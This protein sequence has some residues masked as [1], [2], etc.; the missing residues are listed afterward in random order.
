MNCSSCNNSLSSCSCVDNCPNRTSEFIFDGGFDSIIVPD[1]ANLNDVLLLLEQYTID[2]V[3]NINLNY[4]LSAENCIGLPA[5]TYGY[6]QIFDAINIAICS[7]SISVSA[8]EASVGVIDLQIIDIQTDIIDIQ[9][10]ITDINVEI[11]NIQNEFVDQ[12]PLG[13]MMMYPLAVAPNVKWSLCEGQNLSTTLYADLF[14][15]IGYNFGGSGA[16]FRLPDMRSKFFAGYNAVGSAEY[17]VIGQGAGSDSVSLVNSEIPKHQHVISNG[18]DGSSISNPGDHSHRGGYSFNS[19]LE[20]GD[21]PADFTWDLDEGG[22]VGPNFK[23][24]GAFPYADGSHIHAGET[25]DGASDGLFGSGHENRPE[26]IVFP[27][28]IKVTI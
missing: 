27:W 5:G 18:T 11:V 23:R 3:S 25:G 24:V 15:I 22:S 13:A 10:D 14:S 19:I 16:S 17:Q 6:S 21:I 20:G 28:I 9:T 1:G 7:L 8:L 4:V 12:M 26:F 2:T